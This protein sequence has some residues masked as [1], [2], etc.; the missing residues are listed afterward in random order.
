MPA[1]GVVI[2]LLFAVAV[3]ALLARK[4]RLPYPI[5]LVVGGLA[6]GLLPFAP[7][8][9][10]SPEVVF[11]VFLP[12]LLYQDGW[13]TSVRDFRANLRSIGLLAVGLV[14]ATAAGVAAVAHQLIPGMSWA[15][16]ALLGA[17]VSPTDALAA[18]AILERVGA[19]RRLVTVLEGESLLNDASGLV[20][21]RFA[22]AA[23]TTGAFSVASAGMQ[24][25]LVVAGGIGAGLV[26]GWLLVQIEKR[27]EDPLIEIILS[28]L[29]PFVAYL[30]ADNLLH[31][32][33]VLAVV[34]AALYVSWHAPT[35]FSATTRVQM[36]AVWEMVV[37]VLNGLAFI[38]IGCQ[39]PMILGG[40]AA[41]SVSQLV[42]YAIGAS[43]A[44]MVIRFAW[45]FPGAYLP[46]VIPQVR[47]HDPFPG[48][49]N[50]VA[51]GWA[52]MRGV[53]SLAVALALPAV[54]HRDLLLFLTFCVIL[55]T[56][57][58]Q[59]LSLPLLLRVLHV[60]DDGGELREEEN[61][62]FRAIDAAF[63][64]LDELSREPWVGDDMTEYM[65]R[66]YEKRRKMMATRYGRLDDTQHSADGHHH[67][68]GVDHLADHRARTEALH[69]L[70]LELV[71]TER[72]TVVH[73]RN[74]GSIGD[75]AMRR[76][77]RDLDL[78]EVRLVEA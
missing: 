1:I 28:L 75:G 39:L 70:K 38:L 43:L 40:L 24:F 21:Y 53:L 18:T 11:L 48:L 73:L 56:L 61:A 35:M 51:V 42:T 34:T 62:R 44:V 57:L 32:S 33:G 76:I 60:G 14:L 66:M 67:E 10:L 47:R 13:N 22:L 3:L 68:A 20:A 15:E 29:T 69:R 12:P 55:A 26:V 36:Q 71:T 46:R 25:V 72:M 58:L 74:Q 8:I 2:G 27:L 6:L 31:V 7:R 45:V 5:V 54:P 41:Y 63:A 52:G 23:V 59:G 9:Q 64:R 37:F 17:I 49:R 78:E 19:P 4:V 50:V 30:I 77:Q 16:A 65:R